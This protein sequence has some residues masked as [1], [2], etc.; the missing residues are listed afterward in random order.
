MILYI[1]APV[2]VWSIRLIILFFRLIM[3]ANLTPP[4]DSQIVWYESSGD[5]IV[6]GLNNSHFESNS[7]D[8]IED[9]VPSIEN[10]VFLN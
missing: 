6:D 1:G 3:M 5:G 2:Y 4:P 7:T 8:A 10:C 9:W